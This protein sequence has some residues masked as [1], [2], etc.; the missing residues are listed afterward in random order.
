MFI[1]IYAVLFS[2]TT[3][4]VLGVRLEQKDLSLTKEKGKT[5]H[6]SCEVT[7]LNTD[8]VHWYQKK[9][10]EEALKRILYVKKGSPLVPDNTHPESGDFKVRMQS[11]NYDL[12]I[13][14]LKEIHSGVYYC[15]SW[16]GNHSDR[17]HSE[18]VQKP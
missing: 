8:Y 15:A 7:G 13:E 16:E 4:A 6:I 14:I 5:I 17:K 9:D 3:E 10:G 2:L 11:D 12:K 18:C 1:A